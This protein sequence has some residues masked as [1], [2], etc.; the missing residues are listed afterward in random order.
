[1]SSACGFRDDRDHPFRVNAIT[2]SAA[3]YC[4]Q[5][6]GVEEWSSASPEQIVEFRA[7]FCSQYALGISPTRRSEFRV[8]ARL[9]GPVFL[10]SQS[11]ISPNTSW[12]FFSSSIRL[13]FP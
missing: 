4:Q 6:E 9:A 13:P 1:M 2:P 7:I 5:I 12:L 8:Q 10:S 3:I 11:R